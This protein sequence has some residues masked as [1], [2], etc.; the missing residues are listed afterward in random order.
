MYRNHVRPW[1]DIIQVNEG[2]LLDY[3]WPGQDIEILFVDLMKS[4]DLYNHVV[5]QFLPS[6]IPGVS[7]LIL[8]D[9]LYASSGPWHAVLVEKLNHKLLQVGQTRYNSALYLC[10]EAIT[11]EDLAA[12]NWDQVSYEER[13]LCLAQ[14]AVRWQ[15]PEHRQIMVQIL[16]NYVKNRIRYD[17]QD[18]VYNKMHRA[19]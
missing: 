5:E 4:K 17:S 3:H 11:P 19:G 8:Q 6:L 18:V 12:C 15:D 7:I 10:T 14:N 2:N 13:I 9:F 1:R 16:N